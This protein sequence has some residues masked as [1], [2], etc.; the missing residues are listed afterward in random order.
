VPL[1]V[2][3]VAERVHYADDPAMTAHPPVP[4]VRGDMTARRV[5]EEARVGCAA[6]V[7]VLTPGD[8]VNLEAAMLVHEMNPAARIV[9]RIS[10]S[11]ISR[12][13]DHV[14]RD[15]FGSTLRVIDPS[16][17]AAPHFV[18]AITDAYGDG[19]TAQVARPAAVAPTNVPS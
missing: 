13:L 2:V 8:T 7:L 10:N 4:L 3:D 15:A 19:E 1:V 12:R 9:M 18:E 6:A 16:E 5:L 14:L 11:R 17:H